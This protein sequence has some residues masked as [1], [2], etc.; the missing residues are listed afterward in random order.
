[1]L[2]FHILQIAKS[3]MSE[4]PHSGEEKGMSL[5]DL[6]SSL[7]FNPFVTKNEIPRTPENLRE[8]E[9]LFLLC[10]LIK[11]VVSTWT[12]NARRKSNY[13]SDVACFSNGSL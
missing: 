1:M 4:S 2:F 7:S 10:S 9:T 3:V 6:I 11:N 12:C 8:F 13:F 5:D